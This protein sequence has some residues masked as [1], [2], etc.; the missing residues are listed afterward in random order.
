MTEL[1]TG[2]QMRAIEAA[3]IASGTVTGLELMERAGRGVVE[4]AFNEW[5][6]LAETSH[7]AVVLCGPG[8]NGGDGFVVARLLKQQGWDV[9]VFLYGEAEKLPADAGINYDLWCQLGA[10]TPLTQSA[11]RAVPAADMIVDALFGTGLSRPLEGEALKVIHHMTGINGDSYNRIVAVDCPSGLCLDSGNVLTQPP[12][13]ALAAI[14]GHQKKSTYPFGDTG[15]A[16]L[17]VTFD[18]PKVGHFIGMGPSLCAKISVVDIG[19]RAHR[20][21]NMS[22][23][24]GRD[25]KETGRVIKRMRHPQVQVL[26]SKPFVEDH[27]SFVRPIC[28]F[29]KEHS[30]HKFSHGHAL[31]LSGPTG[32][33]G[34][35]RLTAR[36]ALRIGAGVVTV[37]SPKSAMLENAHHLT[38]IMLSEVDGPQALK[39]SLEDERINALCLGPALGLDNRAAKLVDVALRSKRNTVLDADALTL[40]SQDEVLFAALHQGCVLTPHAGEFKRLFPD[41]AA[42]LDAPATTGPAYSKVDATREAAKRAG[43]VVLFKGADTVISSPDG[44]VSV[45]ASLYERAAPWLATAGSGDVLAGFITGQMARGFSPYHAAE[46]GAYLHTEC[47]LSFGAGLIAEDLPE[48]LPKVFTALGV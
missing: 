46:M 1:I 18:S 13:A 31:V 48:E 39:R 26:R 2:S 40:L 29:G 19:V 27:R 41:V 10:V 20:E 42:K 38:A 3:A 23:Q 35:A 4:A 47:A 33:T 14:T 45:N 17:T 24:I 7:R 12:P 22:A 8:N 37:A 34:A 44:Q 36:G 6:S 25:G 28:L 21:F 16:A 30:A 5:P 11:F 15:F 9:D 32:Q 43:C